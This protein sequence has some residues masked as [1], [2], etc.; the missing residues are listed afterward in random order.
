MK[1]QNTNQMSTRQ[2]IEIHRRAI[3]DMQ[4]MCP[5]LLPST[6]LYAVVSGIVPYVTVFFS[7]RILN[8]LAGQRRPEELWRWVI[9][10]VAVGGVLALLNAVLLRV[11]SAQRDLFYDSKER[12]YTAKMFS[13]DYTDVDNQEA[14]G[15]LSIARQNENWAG[16]GFIRL[17][18]IVEEMSKAAVGVLSAVVLSVSLFTQPV[19]ASAGWYTVL[20]NPLFIL[21]LLGVMVGISLL[22]GFCN[23]K[24]FAIWSTCSEGA[25]LSNRSFNFWVDLG[26][27]RSRT[28]DVRMYNQQNLFLYYNRDVGVFSTIGEMAQKFRGPI[29][30]LHGF[31]AAI[32]AVFTGFVYIFTCLKALGGAFGVGSITQYVG[33]V[34]ALSQNLSSLFENWGVLKTNADFLKPAYQFLDLPNRMYQGSLTTEKRSDRKY[35]VEFRDVSFRYPGAETWALRHVNVRFRVGERMA[36]VGENGSGKTT[37][38]KLLCRLYDPQEGEILLNGIDIRKYNY[39]EYMN[40]FSVVFQDFQLLSQPLGQNVA[41]A[42]DYDRERVEKALIDAGFGER[43]ERLPKGLDTQLYKDFSDGGVEVSGGEAQKIA[44]ARALY[45]NAPFI[46]LD[47]PTAALDPIAEAEIYAQFNQIAGDK[48]A[49]YI[50]HR[51]SSCRFCDEIMVF[52]RGQIVQKGSHDALISDEQGKYAT[53]WH[54]QAQYYTEEEAASF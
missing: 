23:G 30:L 49:I 50:S 40:I 8:E 4:K 5:Y 46:I 52:D 43:L 6:A 38:I 16:W 17:I 7:A 15:L 32:S 41:G 14:R 19:P 11:K 20:N 10:S 18:E 9:L 1:E 42:A 26:L 47:E 28:M 21:L 12:M 34:T 53:L 3:G 54:A 45:K 36:V 25:N 24:A 44:I 39:R 27:Q 35:E 48:T 51:L 22:S 37:F 31:A 33:A 13:L 29:G 2:V